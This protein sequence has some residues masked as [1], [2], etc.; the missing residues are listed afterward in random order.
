VPVPSWFTILEMGI[1]RNFLNK[2]NKIIMFYYFIYT[3]IMIANSMT[4]LKWLRMIH[5]RDCGKIIGGDPCPCANKLRK[6]ILRI[7]ATVYEKKASEKDIFNCQV[8]YNACS[9]KKVVD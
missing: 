6:V 9:V 5:I 4:K 3:L 8:K 1:L 7:P 2:L